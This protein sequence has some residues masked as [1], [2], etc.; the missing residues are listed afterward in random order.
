MRKLRVAAVNPNAQKEK[1]KMRRSN[2]KG[3]SWW[4]LRM[5]SVSAEIK[6]ICCVEQNRHWCFATAWAL[7]YI[8]PK[9][10][11]HAIQVISKNRF[12]MICFF[13]CILPTNKSSNVTWNISP[14]FECFWYVGL[15]NSCRLIPHQESCHV[16]LPRGASQSGI[17]GWPTSLKVMNWY[18]YAGI[19]KNITVQDK[20]RALQNL[21]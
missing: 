17:I 15:F 14:L 11:N 21:S 1:G 9:I 7:F 4:S 18:I 20:F 8:V 10:S 16:L 13:K 19:M 3:S 12:S 2:V 6:K 5:C